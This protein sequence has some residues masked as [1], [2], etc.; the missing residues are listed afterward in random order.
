MRR[1]SSGC[2]R[3]VGSHNDFHYPEFAGRSR[4]RFVFLVRHAARYPDFSP[5]GTGLSDSCET[6]DKPD[7]DQYHPFRI[8]RSQEKPM[9]HDAHPRPADVLREKRHAGDAPCPS[10]RMRTHCPRCIGIACSDPA[11]ARMRTSRSRWNWPSMRCAGSRAYPT[12]RCSRG[13]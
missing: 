6:F 13:N 7:K 3:S 2:R 8:S 10:P 9:W 12:Q 1:C 4:I 5:A 11:C